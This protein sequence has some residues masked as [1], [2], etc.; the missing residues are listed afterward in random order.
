MKGW[1]KNIPCNLELYTCNKSYRAANYRAVFKG[2]SISG[3]EERPSIIIGVHPLVNLR[4]L[5]LHTPYKWSQNIQPKWTEQKEKFLKKAKTKGTTS[6]GDSN[7]PLSVPKRTDN[8]QI[9]MV[10]L[11]NIIKLI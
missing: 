10:Y 5:D 8:P 3:D 2:K 4:I 9:S 11:N 1:Q 6:M 7:I